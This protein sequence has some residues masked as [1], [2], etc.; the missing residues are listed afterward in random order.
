VLALNWKTE[1]T[2]ESDKRRQ[3]KEKC[4]QAL[5]SLTGREACDLKD[6]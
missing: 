5:K 1:E 6:T 4:L 3:M 2:A